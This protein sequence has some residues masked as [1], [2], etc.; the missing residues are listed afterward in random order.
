MGGPARSWVSVICETA[1]FHYLI[2]GGNTEALDGL[3]QCCNHV[4][5]IVCLSRDPGGSSNG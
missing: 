1:R 3:F 4:E 5:V 2:G